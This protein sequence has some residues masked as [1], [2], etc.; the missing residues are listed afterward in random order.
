MLQQW[1][2]TQDAKGNMCHFSRMSVAHWQRTA[3]FLHL[4]QIGTVTG[5]GSGVLGIGRVPRLTYGTQ[6]GEGVFA[7]H[8][9]Q[10]NSLKEVL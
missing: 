5:G 3:G 7:L 9:L 4:S 1:V 2:D 10:G 8:P 6:T